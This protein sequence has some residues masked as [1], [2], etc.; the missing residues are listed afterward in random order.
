[1]GDQGE[2]VQRRFAVVRVAHGFD[3]KG[4]RDESFTRWSESPGLKPQIR[5]MADRRAKAL[6]LIPRAAT[7]TTATA[8]PPPSAKDD[9]QKATTT[10]I[11]TATT[12][13]GPSTASFAKCANDS[14][15]DDMI[16]VLG[17]VLI[18]EFKG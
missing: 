11:T 15:Q 4:V 10:A 16:L 2:E 17:G 14:A 9:N 12:T 8:D 6:R 18:R 1:R 3:C 7:T 5:V 13:A